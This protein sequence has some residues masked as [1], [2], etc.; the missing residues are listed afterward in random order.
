MRGV[1]KVLTFFCLGHLLV[2][3]FGVFL[4]SGS[5]R[6]RRTSPFASSSCSLSEGAPT[7]DYARTNPL[8]AY[9]LQLPAYPLQLQPEPKFLFCSLGPRTYFISEIRLEEG[10]K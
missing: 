2:E 7:A 5:K 6:L 8:R 10:K 9:P 1:T 3:C 4:N